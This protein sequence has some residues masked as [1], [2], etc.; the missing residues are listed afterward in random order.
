MVC[1]MLQAVFDF[2]HSCRLVCRAER[3]VWVLSDQSKLFLMFDVLPDGLWE[4]K[5]QD[6]IAFLKK[7]K[8]SKPDL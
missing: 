2:R 6:F 4:T 5:T 8:K 1:S 3:S 7:E